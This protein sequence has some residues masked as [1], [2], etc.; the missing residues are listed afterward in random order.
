VS[1]RGQFIMTYT[2]RLFYPLDPRA[3]DITIEDVAHALSQICRYGGHT[4]R[5]YS[6]AEH[7]LWVS[8]NVPPEIAR[9][10]LMHDAGEAYVGDVVRPIKYATSFAAYR[11]IEARVDL[12][13]R[14]AFGLRS[15]P[16]VWA[17]IKEID[18][19]MIIDEAAELMTPNACWDRLGEPLD[20]LILGL[21]PRTAE[22]NFLERFREL[23]PE[24]VAL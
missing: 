10:A 22:V 1:D 19:R 4:R 24:W 23:F 12:A 14:D 5:F 2:G 13:C 17:A 18:D 3:W 16:A 8:Y 21:D 11:E 15:D 7:S 9:E 20:Q 6:V